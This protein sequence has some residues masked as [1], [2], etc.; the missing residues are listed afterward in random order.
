[1]RVAQS[2]IDKGQVEKAE[3]IVDYVK[4]HVKTNNVKKSSR[5][6]II[7][8]L[9]QLISISKSLAEEGK[10]QGSI[11]VNEIVKRHLESL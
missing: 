1:M 3:L 9:G 8:T 5:P 10:T 11:E 6:L 4:D 7:E 2:F